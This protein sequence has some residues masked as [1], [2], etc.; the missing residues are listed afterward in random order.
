[1]NHAL[2]SAF[3][4]AGYHT[5]LERHLRDTIRATGNAGFRVDLL[6]LETEGLQ[7]CFVDVVVTCL[8]VPSFSPQAQSRRE[9]AAV[10]KIQ[11][12]IQKCKRKVH[13]HVC[14]LGWRPDFVVQGWEPFG[15]FHPQSHSRL[16]NVLR[17][18]P[19]LRN[20]LH[21]ELS[22]ILSRITGSLVERVSRRLLW[23]LTSSNPSKSSAMEL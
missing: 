4:G 13:N 14:L 23:S 2:R 20:D 9:I 11:E 8:M 18:D 19:S 10:R 17:H 15:S 22:R 3:N 6:V 16:D 12:K 5:E 1:M 21:T 7:D